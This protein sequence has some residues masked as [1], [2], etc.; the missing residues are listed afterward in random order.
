MLKINKIVFFISIVFYCSI[1][2]SK[3][4]EQDI[5]LSLNQIW[6]SKK[7]LFNGTLMSMRT[8]N[9]ERDNENVLELIVEDFETFCSDIK[10]DDFTDE[11]V[12][13]CSDYDF[14][15]AYKIF[16]SRGKTEGIYSISDISKIDD[17]SYLKL[18]SKFRIL[19]KQ[20]YMDEDL[21]RHTYIYECGCSKQDA[22][23]AVVS[24]LLNKGW[25]VISQNFEIRLAK[26]KGLARLAWSDQNLIVNMEVENE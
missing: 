11:I 18:G 9:T 17:R 15:Y 19:Q 14:F 13:S 26:G 12:I 24:Y 1:S 23:Q 22:N 8:F 20:I 4:L 6:I 16:K 25:K 10:L 21:E 5:A 2:Q 7:V 3:G